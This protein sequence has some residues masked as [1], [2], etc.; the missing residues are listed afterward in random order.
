MEPWTPPSTLA[1]GVLTWGTVVVGVLLAVLVVASALL[2][3]KADRRNRRRIANFIRW[4]EALPEY[5]FR[6]GEIP[7]ALREVPRRDWP[8]LRDLLDRSLALVG[9]EEGERLKRVFF[10]AG[11]ESDIAARLR[12]ASPRERAMAAAEVGSYR[13]DAHLPALVPLLED[14]VPF[15]GHTAARTLASS[16]DLTYAGPVMEWVFTQEQFQQE[17]L[18]ALVELFGPALL[19]WLESLLRDRP[20]LAE[21]WKL[22]ALLVASH[23]H[24]ES[25][26]VL[27]ELLGT[28][29]TE[30]RSAAIRGLQTLGD[31][32]AYPSVA[33]FAHHSEPLL[34]MQAAQALGPL[35]GAEA[36][37]ELRRLMADP[38]YDVRR[39]ASH[40]LAG[41]GRPGNAALAEIARDPASDPFAR[42]MAVERLEWVEQRG[43]L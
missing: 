38:V 9:G 19:P 8:A 34:R 4:E 22:F 16:K 2:Q 20:V 17:R 39:H 32:V 30:V 21:G 11:L 42:D 43:R 36:V 29:S 10:A 3:L 35:G 5:L 14:P 15:V 33:P 18:V 28:P 26:P 13:L 24:H 12:H 6:R 25:L 37:A 23:N 31:P 7:P 27:L 1:L 41:L 40:S